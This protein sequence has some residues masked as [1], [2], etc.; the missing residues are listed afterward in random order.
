MNIVFDIDGVLADNRHRFKLIEQPKKDWDMYYDL[1]GADPVI[2]PM[3]EILD[4]LAM[5]HNIFLC[6]GRPSKYR[7][8]TKSWLESAGLWDQV[9]RLFMR[10][11]GSFL[12]NPDIKREHAKIITEEYGPIHMVFEDDPRSVAVWKEFAHVVTEVS[13][14]GL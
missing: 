8:R 13:Y 4:K 1:M 10:P 9:Y 7:Q 11:D 14:V 12:P 2:E 5:E 6:T 3:A